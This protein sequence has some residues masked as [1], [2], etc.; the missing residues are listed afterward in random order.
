M[1]RILLSTVLALPLFLSTI[2]YSGISSDVCVQDTKHPEQ[3]IEIDTST[4]EYR[5]EE[6]GICVLYGTGDIADDGCKI[7]LLD[8]WDAGYGTNKLEATVDICAEKGKAK[9]KGPSVDYKCGSGF[10]I[11]DKDINNNSCYCPV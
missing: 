10:S 8:I 9:A 5:Y 1:F 7:K 3:F 4:G 11:S 6:C 2:A